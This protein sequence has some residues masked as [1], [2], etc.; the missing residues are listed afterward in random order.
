MIKQSLSNKNENAT[1][2]KTKKNSELN[3]ALVLEL[4]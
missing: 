4:N 1:V 3:K 2:L